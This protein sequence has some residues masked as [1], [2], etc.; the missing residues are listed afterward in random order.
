MFKND[1]FPC[2]LDYVFGYWYADT[3][4][5]YRNSPNEFKLQLQLGTNIQILIQRHGI[6]ANK[7]LFE[8][9]MQTK[10]VDELNI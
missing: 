5:D 9:N 1:I 10:S 2:G 6:A 8:C 7:Q 3:E 4:T